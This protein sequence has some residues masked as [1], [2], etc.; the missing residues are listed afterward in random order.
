MVTENLWTLGIMMNVDGKVMNINNRHK[1]KKVL[2][3]I[4]AGLLT[5]GLLSFSQASLAFTEGCQLVAKMAGPA[6]QT[7]PQM[8]GSFTSPDNMPVAFELNYVERSGAWFVYQTEQSWFTKETCAPLTKPHKN[9][10]FEFSPVVKNSQQGQFAVVTPSF[11]IKTYNKPDIDKMAQRYGFKLLTEL[12]SGGAG[13]FDVSGQPSY[14]RMLE[15]LDRDKDIR[16]AAPVLSEK[17]Y[18]LR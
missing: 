18:R 3:L 14:D 2:N 1:A 7:A 16:Y 4:L 10:V 11:M 5:F 9:Q 13:I 8:V 17:R 6:Y 15:I 12:P